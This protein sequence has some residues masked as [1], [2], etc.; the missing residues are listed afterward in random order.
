MAPS[1]AWSVH[2]LG[3]G[4]CG[5]EIRGTDL[6]TMDPLE[7]AE[8]RR[9][10]LE[11]GLL[12]LVDQEVE[13]GV[14]E[15][16]ASRLGDVEVVHPAEHRLPGS[17][18]LRLQSSIPGQG[19]GGGGMYWHADGSWMAAPA[20]ATLLAC[21]EAPTAG[22]GTAFVDAR[23]LYRGLDENRRRQV[24]A[25]VGFYP[26]QRILR[27]ELE[28]L[29]IEDPQMLAAAVDATHP[30][31]RHHAETGDPA[32]IL[33]EQWLR[34][35]VGMSAAGSGA[36]L[37]DLSKAIEE[38]DACYEHAWTAGDVLLWDNRSVLH[39][40]Q[41]LDLGK[42]KVTWRATIASLHP[43]APGGDG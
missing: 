6:A 37:A 2:P 4:G 7:R 9:L 23:A 40:A 34:Q 32:L 29:G 1:S 5:A 10:L 12:L 33:N 28:A 11:A 30:L 14:I 15:D 36:L 26:N 20:Q 39:R 13:R 21:V 42:R 38:C 25:A 27:G 41:P 3:S 19:V 17:E 24:D 31:V 16:F 18:R 35:V 43:V 8:L 22:G